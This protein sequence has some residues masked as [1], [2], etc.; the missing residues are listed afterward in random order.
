[1]KTSKEAKTDPRLRESGPLTGFQLGDETYP[2]EPKTAF[3]NWLYLQ[4]LKH[5]PDLAGQLL[6]Y[7][8]FTDI[9]FSPERQ[10]NS[11]A[12]SAALY[13]GL[14]PVVCWFRIC[15][16]L[17]NIYRLLTGRLIQNR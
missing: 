8:A 9:V 14:T 10:I 13:V 4:G 2:T 7:D 1:M 15:L 16:L 17:G 6:Q 12:E 3:C 11:Q 5:D